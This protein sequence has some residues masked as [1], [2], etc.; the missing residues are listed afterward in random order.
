MDLCSSSICISNSIW[1]SWDAWRSFNVFFSVQ[2]RTTG[3]F[4]TRNCSSARWCNSETASGLLFCFLKSG[5]LYDLV[6][7]VPGCNGSPHEDSGEDTFFWHNAVPRLVKDG[8]AGLPVL[9]AVGDF[10]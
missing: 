8:A 4:L 6:D 2:G 3:T 9:P 10:L 7:L 1:W 5:S